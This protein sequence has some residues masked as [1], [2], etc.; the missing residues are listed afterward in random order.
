[1]DIQTSGKLDFESDELEKEE[2]R[3]AALRLAKLEKREKNSGFPNPL[4]YD[5]YFVNSYSFPKGLHS[6]R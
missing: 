5:Q 2:Q 4:L 6:I 1:M 3:Q